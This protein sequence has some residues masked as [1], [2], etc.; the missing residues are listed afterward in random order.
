LGVPREKL[1]G[2]MLICFGVIDEV[3]GEFGSI[4]FSNKVD[5]IVVDEETGV[6]MLFIN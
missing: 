2:F 5:M 1:K 3:D 4:D 6:M